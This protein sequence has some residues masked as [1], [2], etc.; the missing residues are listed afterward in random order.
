MSRLSLL[1]SKIIDLTSVIDW[2]T[3]NLLGRAVPQ[4]TMIISLNV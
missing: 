4:E 2:R 3:Y 1:G